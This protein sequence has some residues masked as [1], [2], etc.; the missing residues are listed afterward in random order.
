MKK[1]I[2]AG[3]CL[4][5]ILTCREKTKIVPPIKETSK[6]GIGGWSVYQGLMNW[7]DGKAK[8]ESIGMRLPTRAE[9]KKAIDAKLT[10]EWKMDDKGYSN[11]WTSEEFMPDTPYGFDVN[12]GFSVYNPKSFSYFSVRCIS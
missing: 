6:M 10:A 7:D 3:V 9:I 8:C 5:V 12:G 2:F 1:S 4:F 11:Y